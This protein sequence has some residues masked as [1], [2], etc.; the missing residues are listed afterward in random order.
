MRPIVYISGPITKGDRSHNLHQAHVA[1]ERLMLGGFAPINPMLSIQLPFA[2]KPEFPH[3]LWIECDLP[4][5]LVSDAVLRLPGESRGADEEVD[6]AKR[7]GV[8]VFTDIA[9]LVAWKAARDAA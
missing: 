8:P 1:H 3:E 9:D 2:W 4:L 7:M 5:V 6:F